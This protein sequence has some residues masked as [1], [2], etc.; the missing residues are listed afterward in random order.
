M[1]IFFLNSTKQSSR[2]EYELQD[3]AA[4]SHAA[5]VSH[6]RAKTRRMARIRRLDAANIHDAVAGHVKVFRCGTLESIDLISATSIFPGFGSFR[7]ELLDLLPNKACAGDLQAL[8]FFVEVTLPKNDVVNEMFN[9][10]GLL[11]FMLPNL[12]SLFF[13]GSAQIE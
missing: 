4:R 10:S 3:A 6:H 1:H 12:V 13:G 2:R 7:S 9:N 5:K 8:D 11:N